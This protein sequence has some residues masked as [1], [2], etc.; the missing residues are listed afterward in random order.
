MS[1][2]TALLP[3]RSSPSRAEREEHDAIREIEIHNYARQ[4]LE[5]HGAKAG[6]ARAALLARSRLSHSHSYG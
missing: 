1:T 4:L 6:S 5:P 3:D 2:S